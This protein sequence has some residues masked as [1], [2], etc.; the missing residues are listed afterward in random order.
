MEPSRSLPIRMR[1][2]NTSRLG[3]LAEPDSMWTIF[4]PTWFRTAAAYQVVQKISSHTYELLWLVMLNP[5]RLSL[6]VPIE[7]VD[8][9]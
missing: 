9:F 8:E 7:L 3:Q 1:P 4:H 6:V 5:K 2:L